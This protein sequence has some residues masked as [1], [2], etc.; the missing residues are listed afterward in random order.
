MIKISEEKNT[1]YRGIGNSVWDLIPSI[2]ID[3]INEENS[4]EIDEITYQTIINGLS[5]N[6][7]LI[8]KLKQDTIQG[9]LY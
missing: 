3:K 9:K 8:V 1:Y 7:Y 2:V 5:N 4:L 6:S